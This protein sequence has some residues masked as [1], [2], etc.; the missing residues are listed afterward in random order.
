M[1]LIPPINHAK[2]TG[3]IQTFDRLHRRN[4]GLVG[5]GMLNALLLLI[6]LVYAARPVCLLANSGL[7]LKLRQNIA[8]YE[9]RGAL[10][11]QHSANGVLRRIG[12]P[13]GLQHV[14]LPHR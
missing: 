10:L 12:R 2:D 9:D 3:D 6:A 13:C 14:G 7:R 5:A 4:V 11:T 1:T 8:E